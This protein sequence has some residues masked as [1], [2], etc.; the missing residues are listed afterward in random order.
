M[1]DLN[2][3]MWLNVD[4]MVKWIRVIVRKYQVM[5]LSMKVS[6]AQLM[7][8]SI[9]NVIRSIFSLFTQSFINHYLNDWQHY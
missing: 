5:D 8:V 2:S 4:L 6:D 1:F 7:R 3:I 9:F